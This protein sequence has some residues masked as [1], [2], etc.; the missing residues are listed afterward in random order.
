MTVDTT[1]MGINVTIYILTKFAMTTT[2]LKTNVTKGIPTL[3]NLVKGAD[4]VRKMC[5]L[6]LMLVLPPMTKSLK[7][8]KRK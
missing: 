3:A 7:N 1:S 5:V 6:T 2:A 8:L 4:I